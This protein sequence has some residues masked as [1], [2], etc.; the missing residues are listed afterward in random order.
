LYIFCH[1]SL[2]AFFI[3]ILVASARRLGDQVLLNRRLEDKI[4]HLC[5]LATVA[6]DDDAWLLLSEL[7]ILITQHIERLRIVAAG[8]LAGAAE[9]VERRSDS[10]ASKKPP[11]EPPL[12]GHG[13]P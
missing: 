6:N 5:A 2:Y 12:A 10:N 9:F 3:K 4:R 13:E 8:K 11:L 7:R 1:F